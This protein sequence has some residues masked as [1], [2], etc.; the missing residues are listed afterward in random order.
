MSAIQTMLNDK[1]IVK[2]VSEHFPDL[3]LMETFSAA[4]ERIVS[5]QGA[6]GL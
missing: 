3:P 5:S 4:K 6:L 1:E 2:A